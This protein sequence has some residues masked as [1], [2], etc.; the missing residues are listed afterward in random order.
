MLHERGKLKWRPAFFMP[1]QV[2]MLKQLENEDKKQKKPLLDEQE[3]EE[4]SIIVMESICYTL[5][6]KVVI[7]QDGH[8]YEKTGVVHKV[9]HLMEYILLETDSGEEKIMLDDIT[10]VVRL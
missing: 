3:L 7:W 4:I 2:A 8:Y 9:N 5:S 10:A 1:Q 6:I